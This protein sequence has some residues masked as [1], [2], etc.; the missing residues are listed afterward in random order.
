MF[1]VTGRVRAV[2]GAVS[3]A[4]AFGVFSDRSATVSDLS[5]KFSFFHRVASLQGGDRP[6]SL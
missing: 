4:C 5:G 6:S 3:P 2:V 1:F